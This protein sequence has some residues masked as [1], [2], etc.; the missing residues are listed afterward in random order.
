MP[1][2]AT[3]RGRAKLTQSLDGLALL[4]QGF[5]MLDQIDVGRHLDRGVEDVVVGCVIFDGATVVVDDATTVTHDGDVGEVRAD[6]L[7][8]WLLLNRWWEPHVVIMY[9]A[10]GD[11]EA[12]LVLYY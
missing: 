1:V 3:P 11:A 10:K 5:A 6:D 9:D 2:R 8:R 7:G 4:E 12:V